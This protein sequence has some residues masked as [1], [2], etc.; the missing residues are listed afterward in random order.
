MSLN[1]ANKDVLSPCLITRRISFPCQI[2]DITGKEFDA[3]G[4][5]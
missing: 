3:L 2:L 1:K 5:R 4:G